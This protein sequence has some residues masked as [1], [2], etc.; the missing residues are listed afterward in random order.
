[1]TVVP[2]E[3]RHAEF[4]RGDPIVVLHDGLYN[5]MAGRFL[6]LRKDA[7]WVDIEE[8]NGKVRSHPVRW[9]RHAEDYPS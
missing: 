6:K 3:D 2:T 7:N 4:R 1:M 8:G 5:G 9:L